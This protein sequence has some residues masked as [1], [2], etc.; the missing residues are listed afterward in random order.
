MQCPL[1][2]R[3]QTSELGRVM[4][5]MCQKRTSAELVDHVVGAGKQRWRDRETERFGGLEIDH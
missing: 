5:A 4:S 2:L 1:Y 3:K